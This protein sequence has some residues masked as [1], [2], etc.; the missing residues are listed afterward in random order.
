[1]Y[2]LIQITTFVYKYNESYDYGKALR[3][4]CNL[5]HFEYETTR[6]QVAANKDKIAFSTTENYKNYML[7]VLILGIIISVIAWLTFLYV[8]HKAFFNKKWFKKNLN[9]SINDNS[10]S[11]FLTFWNYIQVFLALMNFKF[12]DNKIISFYVFFLYVVMIFILFYTPIALISKLFNNAQNEKGMPNLMMFNTNQQMYIPYIVI[13]F[14][15]I[16]LFFIVFIIGLYYSDNQEDYF[17]NRLFTDNL[18]GALV[19]F[20]V[21]A[22]FIFFS[23]IIQNIINQFYY[24]DYYATKTYNAGGLSVL[25]EFYKKVFGYGEDQQF[26]GD[27]Y[28]YIY[29]NH[30]SGI[31]VTLFTMIV[32]MIIILSIINSSYFNSDHLDAENTKIYIFI[33]KYCIIMPSMLLF[34]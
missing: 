25:A 33:M 18:F 22:F 27:T 31:S 2:H 5:E 11:L 20:A 28:K 32:V 1:M 13:F 34:V 26:D 17:H 7:L 6:F 29:L 19:F 16:V 30:I 4:L 3:Y 21:F 24:S 23:Y 14:L 12:L 10:S 9:N 15:I 8:L